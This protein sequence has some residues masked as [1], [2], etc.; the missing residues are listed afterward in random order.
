MMRGT[1]GVGGSPLLVA[2]GGEVARFCE[3]VLSLSS[4]L[5]K[6]NK[7]ATCF[8]TTPT[9][10]QICKRP[11]FAWEEQLVTH[12]HCHDCGCH[13]N[14]GPENLLRESDVLKQYSM[15]EDVR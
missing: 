6:Q 11:T 15:S 8:H 2:F 4:M 3:L 14:H 9:K 5:L 12:D 1:L 10:K 7:S 13:E